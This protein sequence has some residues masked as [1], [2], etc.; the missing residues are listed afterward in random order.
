MLEEEP[1]DGSANTAGY[2]PFPP[3][4]PQNMH[5]QQHRQQQRPMP[6]NGQ[7]HPPLQ[8]QPSPA[9]GSD[10]NGGFGGQMNHNL[11]D[12]GYDPMLDADPFGLSASMHFPTQFSFDATTR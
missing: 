10:G 3:V 2:P 11:Y 1:A 4:P 12:G 9:Q 6:T 8:P 7:H 5:P